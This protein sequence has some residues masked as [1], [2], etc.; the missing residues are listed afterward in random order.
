MPFGFGRRHNDDAALVAALD[1]S[2]GV[3]E[4][5]AKGVVLKA[6]ACF[7]RILGYAPEEIVGRHHSIFVDPD[8]ARSA[9][10]QEFWAKLRRGEFD[11]REGKRVRKGGGEAWIRTSYN[12]VFDAKGGVRG[13]LCVVSD[14]TIEKLKIVESEAKLEAVD[15]A[16]AVIELSPKGEILFANENFLATMGYT[17]D[18]IRGKHHRMFVDPTFANSPEYQAFWSKLQSGGAV[19]DLFRRVAKGG[20]L[21]LLQ[22]SYSPVLDLKGQVAKVVKFAFDVSDLIDLG[23]ALSRLAQSDVERGIGGEFKPMFAAIRTDFNLAQEKLKATMLSIASSAE[24]VTAGAKEI[25][26]ASENLSGRTEQQAASLEETA[27][28]LTTVTDAVKSTAA[29]SQ[30]ASRLVTAARANAVEGGEVVREANEAMDRIEKSSLEI[31][32]IIGVIDEIAF[33]T[34]LLALNAGVEAARAGE[35]GR[36]FAVV[37]S[38][39]RG[40]AQRSAD[41]AKQIKTLISASSE[42]VADGVRLVGKTG[43]ALGAII[44]QIEAVKTQIAHISQGAQDQATALSEVNS[45]V[46][47]MDQGTQQNAAMAEEASAAGDSMLAEANK[48]ASLIG[49]FRLGAPTEKTLRAELKRAAPHAFAAKIAPKTAA[50][51]SPAAVP[52]PASAARRKDDE[53][54]AAKPASAASAARAANSN[55]T[56]F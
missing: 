43:S 29:G 50:K 33:Q 19:V 4:F 36:G 7:C 17:L 8:H 22:A 14:I 27:A 53:R 52:K 54:G 41:A 51:T 38:E 49:Q 30:E 5:D 40:L 26:A 15:H 44:E 20:R 47:Q 11:T 25:A 9:E 3:I 37:A 31:G 2:L 35:A 32:Q 23:A 45:A 56:E 16:M 6:N 21:V 10:Y 13:I 39:V 42:Q 18:E 55:W 28:A 24:A 1:K 12:P 48:L 34:N 46:N